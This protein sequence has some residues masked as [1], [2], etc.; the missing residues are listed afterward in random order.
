VDGGPG[1]ARRHAAALRRRGLFAELRAC[2][3][4]GRPSLAETL[5][6]IRA[7]RIYLVPMLMAEGYTTDVVL[8]AALAE[9]SVAPGRLTACRPLGTNPRLA[10]LVAGRATAACRRLAWRPAT[11]TLLLVGHGTPRHPRSSHSAIGLAARIVEAGGFAEVATAFLDAPPS[12]PEAIAHC[13]AERCVAVGLFADRGPHG[14]ADVAR[15]L[16]AVDGAAYAGPIGVDPAIADL[17]LGQVAAA[18][19]LRSA[20]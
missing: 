20:A 19:R 13:A 16:A 12:V 1:A 10:S 7:P 11:T 8:P 17:V 5:A 15:A 2:C 14:E 6:A 18:D 9:T 3:L 4:K